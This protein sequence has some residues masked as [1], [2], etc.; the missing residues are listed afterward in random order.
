VRFWRKIPRLSTILIVLLSLALLRSL[1]RMDSLIFY[2]RERQ[3]TYILESAE[4]RIS[5]FRIPGG[6]TTG[7]IAFNSSVPEFSIFR[8]ALREEP[9]TPHFAGLWWGKNPIYFVPNRWFAI[10]YG[11]FIAPLLLPSAIRLT[12][13]YLRRRRNLCPHCAYDLRGSPDRCPECGQLPT[14]SAV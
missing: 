14:T 2:E 9:T 5:F 6:F 3:H 10:P 8:N 13:R 1:L 4:G 12:R 7:T 11:A